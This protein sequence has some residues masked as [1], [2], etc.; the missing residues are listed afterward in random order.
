MLRLAA[1]PGNSRK[2]SYSIVGAVVIVILSLSYF[3]QRGL[4]SNIATV[5]AQ[6]SALADKVSKPAVPET[7]A[8]PQEDVEQLRR[9]IKKQRAEIDRLRSKVARLEDRLQPEAIRDRLTQ[10]ESRGQSLHAELFAI[11]ER[12]SS[13]QARLDEVNEQLRP[14]NIEALPIY[15][16]TRPEEVRE[17]ARR[18]LSNEA[19]R[20]QSQ[21]DLLNQNKNRIQSSLSASDLMTLNLQGQLQNAA[22]RP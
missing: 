12:E 13:L 2:A 19:G 22:S 10:E 7:T 21:L 3:N 1:K 20:I 17:S 5:A 18:R 14:A 11:A 6:S 16:S 9:T 4:W 8:Q 15:G